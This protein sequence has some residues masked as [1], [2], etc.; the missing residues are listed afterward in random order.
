MASEEEMFLIERMQRRRVSKEARRAFIIRP[1]APL[2]SQTKDNVEGSATAATA[3]TICLR[4]Q[5]GRERKRDYISARSALCVH[6][7]AANAARRR[8]LRGQSAL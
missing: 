6:R 3:A 7:V 5:E 2:Y 4:E 1:F 8:P